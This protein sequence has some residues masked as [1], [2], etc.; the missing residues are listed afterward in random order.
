VHSPANSLL[1]HALQSDVQR[2]L[3]KR[4]QH[5]QQRSRVVA[6]LLAVPRAWH[7]PRRLSL[8][9]DRELRDL[10]HAARGGDEVARTRLVERFDRTLRAIAGSYRLA[11]ADVDDVVQTT[12]LRLF[13][14]MDQLREPAA[15][16]AWLATTTRRESLRHL[17]NPVRE[18]PTDDP[19]LGEV[20]DDDGPEARFLSAERHAIL[21]HA[22]ATLPDRH[23]RLM[24]VL[25]ADSSLKYEQI[26][27]ILAIPI[28]S[29]GPIRAR[30]LDRLSRN[31]QLQAI[32]HSD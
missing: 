24:T 29:I 19:E 18:R 30:C 16:G 1:V 13:T 3:E 27:T 22:L 8:K 28:G 10:V 11:P 31:R 2:S 6:S 4:E 17:Q 12:W 15:I 20:A 5:E 21:A 9:P 32:R 23:R 25:A 14:R 26:S 7:G